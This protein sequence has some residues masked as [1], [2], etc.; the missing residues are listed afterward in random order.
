MCLVVFE[1]GGVV[2]DCMGGKNGDLYQRLAFH[3]TP[4]RT[5]PHRGLHSRGLVVGC[6][7]AH[8]CVMRGLTVAPLHRQFAPQSGHECAAHIYQHKPSPHR[9][10]ANPPLLVCTIA[11][12]TTDDGALL[13]YGSVPGCNCG[14]VYVPC[15][16]SA[17][18]AR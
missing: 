2:S 16:R 9:Q 4:L 5:S 14:Q 13:R 17:E 11:P 3:C 15:I 12:F 1:E 8:T 10:G 18:S 6:T 7:P